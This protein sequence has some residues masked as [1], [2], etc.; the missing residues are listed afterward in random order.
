MDAD[1]SL[2]NAMSVIDNHGKGIAVVVD[3]EQ[4]LLATVTDGDLRRAIL[5]GID[6]DLS[7][8][9][10]RQKQCTTHAHLPVVAARIGTPDTELIALMKERSVRQVPLLDGEH[11][12]RGLAVL[13]DLLNVFELP[14]T[15]V[16]M[17]GGFGN[18]LRPLT[19][20]V[21][22]PMLLI[23]GRPLLEH[24]LGKL[25]EAGVQSV[26]ITTHYLSENIIRHFKDGSA[27][28]INLSYVQEP[29]PL[30][31]AAALARV[32]TG[33]DPLLVINGDILTNVNVRA[34]LEFHREHEACMTIGVRQFDI[35]MPFGV[36]EN[37]GIKVIG[38]VEKPVLRHLI[39]A[40]IYILD[41][42]V[43]GLIPP[44]QHF[45]MPDLITAAIKEGGTVVNFLVR[46][47]WLDINRIEHYQKAGTDAAEGI[48]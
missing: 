11:R 43:C 6:L 21:P 44:H 37:D 7:V 10:L 48:V 30:G 45:D 9:R 5:A 22:K 3:D 31:T 23:N 2:R 12:V 19:E 27:F 47:Y 20:S 24:T 25:R 35:E 33:S 39:N 16:I 17:A 40:G 28:G 1:C 18:R 8:V 32:S 36:V 34:M 13:D 29:K 15:G 26:H 41:P 42:A 4:R 38:I 46:E 14:V